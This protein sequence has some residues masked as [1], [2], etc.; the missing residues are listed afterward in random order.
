[1]AFNSALKTLHDKQCVVVIGKKKTLKKIEN[2][3]R[4]TCLEEKN[5]PR[6]WII[7][8]FSKDLWFSVGAGDAF[9]KNYII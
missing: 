7:N 8:Y 9:N 6:G 5:L 1:M 3:G 4:S 2:Y